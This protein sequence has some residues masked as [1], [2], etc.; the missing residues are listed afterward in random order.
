MRPDYRAFLKKIFYQYSIE[1]RF[2]IRRK[3][4]IG[5][6]TSLMPLNRNKL[7]PNCDNYFS[8]AFG[9]K[10]VILQILDPFDYKDNGR[11][12]FR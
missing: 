10:V 6:S 11:I 8:M 12:D 9:P 7:F 5:L 1:M 2:Q 4:E 3:C